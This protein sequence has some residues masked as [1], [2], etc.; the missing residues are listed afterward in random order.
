MGDGD[1]PRRGSEPR[2]A[3]FAG[4]Q[5][6][7]PGLDRRGAVHR[8]VHE[9]GVGT[10]RARMRPRLRLDEFRSGPEPEV[11]PVGAFEHLVERSA[12]LA[13]VQRDERPVGRPV[14]AD[15]DL[16]LGARF[17]RG[18]QLRDVSGRVVG[19]DHGGAGHEA[20]GDARRGRPHARAEV[21]LREPRESQLL[22]RSTGRVRT[23]VRF[24]L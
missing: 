13:L 21:L 14:H 15:A 19:I 5:R 2:P 3:V 7:R 18:S 11:G 22:G 20:L 8:L 17:V 1:A 4:G 9:T 10:R 16:P 12:R 6:G 24:L 23:A